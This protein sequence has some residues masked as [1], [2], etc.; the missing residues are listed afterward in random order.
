MG[1]SHFPR[2]LPSSS[3]GP[4]FVEIIISASCFAIVLRIGALW[5]R[6][7]GGRGIAPDGTSKGLRFLLFEYV[8]KG[9]CL[10]SR[11]NLGNT[12]QIYIR[13]SVVVEVL[14]YKPEEPRKYVL[15]IYMYMR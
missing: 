15:N 1:V 13:S 6:E 2:V 3:N 11:L 14:C 5:W 7:T 10:S 4:V 12:Y 8:E 9:L